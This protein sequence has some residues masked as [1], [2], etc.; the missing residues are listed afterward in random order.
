[1][2][3]IELLPG[4]RLL[5]LTDGVDEAHDVAGPQFG[6][7]RVADM[8][9][10]HAELPPVEFVRRLTRAVTDFRAGPLADDATAVCLDW[11]PI[12]AT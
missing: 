2:Q 5:L 6:L 8:L 9:R 10:S 1:M 12:N 4:D 3:A 7:D 11:S